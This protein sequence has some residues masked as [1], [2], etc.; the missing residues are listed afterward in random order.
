MSDGTSRP[1]LLLAHGAGGSL[2]TNYGPV[3]HRLTAR[4]TVIGADYPGT[5]STPRATRPLELD[6]LADQLLAVADAAGA[7]RFTVSGFSLGGP[8]AIRLA[9]RHPQRVTGL[10]LTAPFARADAQVRLTARVWR[11]LAGSGDATTLGRFVFAH[12]LSPAAL[13]AMDPEELD[14][15]AKETGAAAPEGTPDQVDLVERLDVTADLARITAPTLVVSPVDDRLVPP[16][17]HRAVAAGIAGARLVEI[18]GGH[19]PFAE[20]PDRWAALLTGG[21]TGAVE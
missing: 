4:Y 17:L 10:V 2:A 9:A 20:Q 15:A 12:A 7:E 11:T 14:A 1:A 18:P 13:E 21:V 3:M 8:V 16:R 6:G 19:L 5:G